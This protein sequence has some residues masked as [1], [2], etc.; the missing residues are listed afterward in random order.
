MEI[1]ALREDDDRARF[2]SGDDALDRFLHRFA[3]QN[4]FRHFIGVTY[5]A[6][7]GKRILGY[8]TVAPG[9]VEIDGLP[10]PDRRSLPTY[11]LPILRLARLAV[12]EHGRGSGIGGALLRYV[13]NLAV[14]MADEFGCVGVIVDAK[15]AATTFY[16]KYGFVPVEAVEG[17]SDARPE[18]TAMFLSITAIR[19]AASG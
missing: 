2:G 4:Q 6:I 13:L 16:A 1:R 11:P 10:S 15:D 12:D 5:V 17:R 9:H 14:R 7:E 18:P 3:G 8:A 19:K